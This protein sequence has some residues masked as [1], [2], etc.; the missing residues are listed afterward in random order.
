MVNTAYAMAPP[1]QGQSGGSMLLGFVPIFAMFAIF[2]F[3]LIKPQQKKQKERQNMLNNIKEGDNITTQGGILGK[4]TKIKDDIVTIQ[5]ADQVRI[6]IT[7]SS[8]SSVK[9]K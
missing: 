7:R 2:Y 1:P 9:V 8:V 6:K 4:I 3:L 5:V